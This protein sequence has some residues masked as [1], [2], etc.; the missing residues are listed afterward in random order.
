MKALTIKAPSIE[1]PK[2]L[3]AEGG[4]VGRGLCPLPRKFLIIGP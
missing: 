4:K 1:V 2:A 3:G